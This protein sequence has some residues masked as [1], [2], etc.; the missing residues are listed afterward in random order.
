MDLNNVMQLKYDKIYRIVMLTYV[1]HMYF[2]LNIY[3]SANLSHLYYV[4]VVPIV[5]GK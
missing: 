2:K 3:T 1:C 5:N 4:D